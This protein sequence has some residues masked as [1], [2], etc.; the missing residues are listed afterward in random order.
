MCTS[1]PGGE[2]PV[3]VSGSVTSLPWR[4]AVITTGS[5]A[6]SRFPDGIV[7]TDPPGAPVTTAGTAGVG[8]GAPPGEGCPDGPGAA[9]WSGE[10]VTGAAGAAPPS[11]SVPRMNT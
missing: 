4:G 11:G 2:A 3:I 6:W 9:G 10:G 8:E 1:V 7:W 5:V